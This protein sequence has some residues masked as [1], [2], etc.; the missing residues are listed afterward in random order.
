[1]DAVVIDAE[2]EAAF[3]SMTHKRGLLWCLMCL[4]FSSGMNL[5]MH[6][7]RNGLRFGASA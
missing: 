4:A 2:I 5:P 1:M 6:R 7:G 3:H